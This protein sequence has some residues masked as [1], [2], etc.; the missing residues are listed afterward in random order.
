MNRRKLLS[1]V[2]CV[3]LIFALSANQQCARSD[4]TLATGDGLQV[5]ID[6]QGAIT[7]LLVSGKECHTTENV[8][9]SGFHVLDYQNGVQ[10]TLPGVVRQRGN[11]KVLEAVNEDAQ[12]SLSA[13]FES[14]DTYI[15]VTG[16]IEDLA[17]R[18][19][20]VD[21]LF[22]LPVDA[23]GWTWW[24]D[25]NNRT[26]IKPDIQFGT[27]PKTFPVS[28]TYGVNTTCEGNPSEFFSIYPLNCLISQDRKAGIAIA[29]SPNLPCVHSIE[30]DA[31]QQVFRIKYRFG[32]TP[33]AKPE[34][35]SKAT[36]DFRLYKVDANWGFR[37][38]LKRYYAMYPDIFE[39]V[40]EKD[41]LLLECPIAE[42]RLA[43]P[44]WNPAYFAY[45]RIWNR[46]MIEESKEREALA[47]DSHLYVLPGQMEVKYLDRL[48]GE[49]NEAMTMYENA[50]GFPY[51]ERRD[52][53]LTD[54]SRHLKR[55]IDLAAIK[56]RDDAYDIM[57]RNSW[58]G[59]NSITFTLNPDPDLFH[60]QGNNDLLFSH[61]RLEK[62]ERIL[63]DY[64]QFDGIYTDSFHRW[65]KCLNYRRD[66]FR[67][68]DF[69]LTHDADGEVCIYNANSHFEWLQQVKEFAEN[70]GAVTSGNGVKPGQMFNAFALD[71][72][73]AENI[74]VGAF[75]WNRVMAY[76][77]PFLLSLS[78]RDRLMMPME[79]FL[80]HCILYGML[81]SRLAPS[82]LRKKPGHLISYDKRDQD[83]VE[84]YVPLII[85]ESSLGWEP[86]THA[87][88]QDTDIQIERFG[89]KNG[90]VLLAL[91][92]HG[93]EEK[94][95]TVDVDLSAIGF[96]EIESVE[97]L[98][99]VKSLS[100]IGSIELEVESSGLEVLLISGR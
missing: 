6:Q 21:V 51:P 15:S 97:T 52:A 36:F 91:Y 10:Y 62:C 92:N 19:R 60:D 44:D 17:G 27:R 58:W 71:I 34:L 99:D 49:Y 4:L 46:R 28:D 24:G 45:S 29:V 13:V 50:T 90:Q 81:P 8:R 35:R 56:T 53:V 1:V 41:G 70:R 100:P 22:Q 80:K 42:E 93:T 39:R 9:N 47:I 63:K 61:D 48:P 38:G 25:I 37:D 67:Y 30:Y 76:Q 85:R 64:P 65:G 77:K 2:S 72:L 32:L 82:S 98:I 73:G 43:N 95:V 96:S 69:P 74:K 55:W 66:H 68:A 16:E 86:V 40:V 12:I 83:L 88:T 79:S 33:D 59:D 23:T 14:H 84:C 11:G 18:D 94:S 75:A 20:G 57:I 89:P 7:A 31:G 3:A 87:T 78:E 5:Q 26:V 54:R